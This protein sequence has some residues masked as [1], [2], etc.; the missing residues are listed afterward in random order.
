MKDKGAGGGRYTRIKDDRE[1][2][3]GLQEKILSCLKLWMEN[4]D[5]CSQM[6]NDSI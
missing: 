2:K 5:F 4:V 3:T 6:E 1:A